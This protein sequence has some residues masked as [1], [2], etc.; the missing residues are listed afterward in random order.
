MIDLNKINFNYSKEGELDKIRQYLEEQSF[1]NL[2]KNKKTIFM[3]TPSWTGTSLFRI[4][5]PLLAMI[6]KYPD[7]YNYCYSEHE[8]FPIEWLK[9]TDLWIQHRAG[10]TN[11]TYLKFTK[12]FPIDSKKPV[13]IHDIDDNEYNLPITHPMRHLWLE[14]GKDK[15]AIYQIS[16]SDYVSTTGRILQREFSKYNKF[17]NIKIFKNA[18]DWSLPQWNE[19]INEFDNV[20]IGWA[21]LTSHFEDI[22]KMS[23]ILKVI[24]DKYPNVKFKIAGISPYDEFYNIKED[25]N[26]KRIVEKQSITDKKV[27]YKYRVTEL[28]KDFDKDRI[29]LLGILSHEEYGKFYNKWNLNLA[30]VEHNE[31]NRCKSAIKVYEGSIYKSINVY[32]NFGGYQNEFTNLA[33]I[34]LKKELLKHC[35]MQTENINEWV[36]AISFWIEN[37]KNDLWNKVVEDQYNFVKKE[38]N[39][40]NQIDERIKFYD[41]IIEKNE[42]SYNFK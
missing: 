34:E 38:F 22:K 42:K 1:K 27:T 19:T 20:I 25:K 3:S 23:I 32:S 28:F 40:Y 13:I 35:A 18:F 24:H 15:M 37:Y 26:G 9:K 14:H 39:I 29:E 4:M 16:N 11:S 7:K 8:G 12:I 6:K 10:N 33:P 2:D 5:I 17:E 41:S 30:Y 21:G 36:K 31:F